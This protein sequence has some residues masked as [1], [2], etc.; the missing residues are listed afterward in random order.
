MP[1]KL[2]MYNS[3]PDYNR[4]LTAQLKLAEFITLVHLFL[5]KSIRLTWP[6]LGQGFLLF[7]G[8]EKCEIYVMK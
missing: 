7:E 6:D 3:Y 5:Q 8:A 4:T 1:L 2:S